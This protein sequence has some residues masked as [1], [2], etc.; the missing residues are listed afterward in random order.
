M[1]RDLE[2]R[3]RACMTPPNAPKPLRRACSKRS[4]AL[5]G[6]WG[7]VGDATMPRMEG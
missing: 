1:D 7:L 2:E 3:R 6:I 5:E 4:A